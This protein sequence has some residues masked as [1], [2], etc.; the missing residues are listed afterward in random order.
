MYI[1]GIWLVCIILADKIRGEQ[2][3]AMSKESSNRFGKKPHAETTL[4][5]DRE[6]LS[7][8]DCED[9]IYY[10][11][12]DNGQMVRSRP[13]ESGDDSI[14]YENVTLN[15]AESSGMFQKIYNCLDV[16]VKK[17]SAISH[18]KISGD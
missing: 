2:L 10:K 3:A 17:D 13:K 4:I 12:D 1:Q 15:T 16:W 14:Y 8:Q 5:E 18:R 9:S 7:Y 11:L 6:E